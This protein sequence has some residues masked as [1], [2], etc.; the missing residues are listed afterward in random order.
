MY[1]KTFILKNGGYRNKVFEDYELWLKI[2]DK[3]DFFIIP[4]VLLYQRNLKNSLSKNNI[5]DKYKIQYEIQK[6]YYDHEKIKMFGLNDM[7]E[8]LKFRGWR[9]YFYGS[10]TMAY[11]YWMKLGWSILKDYKVILAL[12]IMLLP[13]TIFVLFKE[14]RFRYRVEYFLLYF[15]RNN[16]TIRTNF[17]NVMKSLVK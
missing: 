3:V 10:R 7:N 9:E 11:K 13:K 17:N 16:N 4:E 5:L 6:P 15:S 8:Q 12:F 1:N 2:C 14:I